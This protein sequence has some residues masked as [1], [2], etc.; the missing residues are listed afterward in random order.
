[1]RASSR[2]VLWIFLAAALVRILAVAGLQEPPLTGDAP[3]YD[4]LAM[5]LLAGKG[6][7]TSDG[8]P[9]AERP[10]LYAMFLAA[11]FWFFGHRLDAVYVIQGLIDAGS[12][13]LIYLVGARVMGPAPGLLAG[14]LAVPYLSLIAATRMVLTET[15][16][17]FLMLVAFWFLLE[18]LER[19]RTFALAACG[20]A[21]GLA[22][23]TRG[24][25]LLFPIACA[26]AFV[27][28]WRL[29]DTIKRWSILALSYVLVLLPWTMRNWHTFHIVVPVA[30]QGGKVLYASYLPPEGKLFGKFPQDA[31]MAYAKTR[32]SET[33]GSRFLVR[34]TLEYVADRP[35]VL[36]KLLLL[37]LGF[38]FVPFDW[39]LFGV[40]QGV[41]NATYVLIVPFTMIGMWAARSSGGLSKWLWLILGYFLFMSLV[42]YGSPR[43]RLP[44]EPSFLIWAGVGV[45][46]LVRRYDGRLFRVALAT[47]TY[48]TANVALMCHSQAV[49]PVL[50]EA[51]R[52][53]G[54]W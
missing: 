31:A 23:L 48:S 8:H 10:P 1:M 22:T 15:L 20:A 11:I 44:V 26:L 16:F 50:A 3:V 51:L 45:H 53:V 52:R 46:W 37:K 30:T 13:A 2:T 14:L 28:T 33:A 5:G 21:L 4:R 49:K 54:L 6:Y 29:P 40:G 9:T 24:T 19:P 41:W 35:Q 17:V 39:E 12:C 43:M 34:K 47:G 25:S 38:F 36:P 27:K 32:L 18:S 7:V 42:F